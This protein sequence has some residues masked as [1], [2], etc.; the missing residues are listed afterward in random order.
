MSEFDPF[1]VMR[2]L[3][4]PVDP[5]E[6][7]G[8][9]LYVSLRHSLD[10]H[11]IGAPIEETMPAPAPPRRGMLVAAAV[12]AGLFLM[13]GLL[14]W[15]APPG[16]QDANVD[17]LPLSEPDNAAPTSLVEHNDDPAVASPPP[18]TLAAT[19][20]TLASLPG[21]PTYLDG[22]SFRGWTVLPA[23]EFDGRLG[24]A[25][26]WTGEQLIVWGGEVAAAGL[27]P[28]RGWPTTNA[29]G[30]YDP[31]TGLWVSLPPAPLSARSD[32]SALWTGAEM[33]VIGG[34][35][36]DGAA[37]DPAARSW[38]ELP[39][40]PVPS[41]PAAVWTGREAIL[42][43][44]P[45]PS[46]V[47]YL[48]E[49]N[50]WRSIATPEGSE[51]WIDPRAVWT[52]EE[53]IVWDVTLRGYF[54]AAERVWAF[55]IAAYNPVTDSW[56][57]FLPQEFEFELSNTT[58]VWTG[59]ELLL[60]GANFERLAREGELADTPPI[61]AM[62]LNPATAVWRS[63]APPP[64]AEEIR[65]EGFGI[66]SSVWAGDRLLVWA[67]DLLSTEP[68]PELWAY[69]PASDSWQRGASTPVTGSDPDL[70]W[71]GTTLY[72]YGGE[73][74][75]PTR[76]IITLNLPPG[77][78]LP[79]PVAAGGTVDLPDNVPF[80][81]FAL[82]PFVQSAFIGDFPDGQ[83]RF[84]ERSD[85]FLQVDAIS[86]VAP[87]WNGWMT[88]ANGEVWWF[89]DS[90]SRLPVA[91]QNEPD[92]SAGVAGFSYFLASGDDR[93]AQR[94]WTVVPGEGFLDPQNA[95][96]VVRSISVETR[97]VRTYTEAPP[98]AFPVTASTTGLLLN[99]FDWLDAGDGFVEDPATFKMMLVEPDGT[100]QPLW[101]GF[102][103]DL[104]VNRIIWMECD[105]AGVECAIVVSS[106]KGPSPADLRVE[107][108]GFSYQT[109]AVASPNGRWLAVGVGRQGGADQAILIVDVV[110]GS[111][112][113]LMTGRSLSSYFGP[114]ITWSV[115][116]DW[117][118]SLDGDALAIRLED[119]FQV[120]VGQ[121][122]PEGMVVYGVAAR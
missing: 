59:E 119:G 84:Y 95:R 103:L 69:D 113:T 106:I 96:S 42:F 111:Y 104:S 21:E 44:G 38:R 40:N 28:D 14:S 37:Y 50:S 83:G 101:A 93:F 66:H 67:G 11:A 43:G 55:D 109:G 68:T 24:A 98:D 12:V 118:L 30:S 45:G 9:E 78:P 94:I 100:L 41:N 85:T 89:P 112:K 32:A 51:A 52:G 54:P 61:L 79:L 5:P 70:I 81:I 91:L 46:G 87:L 16:E 60:I 92:T 110:D 10:R 19:A 75:G 6:S 65:I 80:E 107:I 121:Y 22:Y 20:T 114:S 2:T 88:S 13:G 73:F 72:A 35:G 71:D 97:Q 90:I 15:L 64:F 115:D 3:D 26:V 63:L 48:P 36:P 8:E 27:R 108:P 102:G 47:A 53:M 77:E 33:L 56:R 120:D 25:V 82:E 57:R 58:G 99:S 86:N 23:T 7:F 116:S 29:G 76:R 105:Q 49:A 39:L 4:G 122:L 74:T 17:P 1:A 62:A 31:G 117:L 18:S 34:G